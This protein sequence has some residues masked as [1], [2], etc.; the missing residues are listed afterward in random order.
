MNQQLNDL[1]ITEEYTDKWQGIVDT[2]A[3]LIDVPSGTI[4]V[5]DNQENQY[6]DLFSAL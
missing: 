3:Q 4:C 6:S 2:M 5:L 1:Q